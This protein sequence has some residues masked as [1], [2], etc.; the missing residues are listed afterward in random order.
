MEVVRKKVLREN[1]FK[2]VHLFFS[3]TSSFCPAV[4]SA[5]VGNAKKTFP[6]VHCVGQ[7]SLRKCDYIEKIVIYPIIVKRTRCNALL[8]RKELSYLL[9][10]MFLTYIPN[11]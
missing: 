4:T 3:A 8:K 7:T 1:C 11:Y 5:A 9:D 10:T 6:L 2:L